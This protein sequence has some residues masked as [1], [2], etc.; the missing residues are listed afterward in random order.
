MVETI[1][2][3]PL[4]KNL[5]VRSGDVRSFRLVPESPE[6]WASLQGGPWL[7]QV[8][9]KESSDEVAVEL[10]TVEETDSLGVI[11]PKTTSDVWGEST[12]TT[13][14]GVYDV[15]GHVSGTEPVTIAEGTF[16]IERDVSR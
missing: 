10:I 2:L 16:T 15:Q 7:A 14:R 8:R 12:L 3:T 11:I 1:R 4:E 6:L 9:K 5:V 13:W